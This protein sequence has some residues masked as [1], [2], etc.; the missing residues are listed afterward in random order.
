MI[1][2][3]LPS[4]VQMVSLILPPELVLRRLDENETSQQM[5]QRS[6]DDGD[7]VRCTDIEY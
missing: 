2:A 7:N 5:K 4:P 6:D 1:P 3:L